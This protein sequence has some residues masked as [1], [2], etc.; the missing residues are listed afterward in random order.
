MNTAA[1]HMHAGTGVQ[2]NP[3]YS[4]GGAVLGTVLVCALLLWAFTHPLPNAPAQ[5][6][7][8]SLGAAP[9]PTPRRVPRPIS[10]TQTAKT[11]T[12]PVTAKPVV[13]PKASSIKPVPSLT[14]LDLNLPGLT[15]APPTA[16]AFQPQVFNPYSDLD[17]ALT[18]PPPALQM[19]N[20]QSYRS[21][22][23]DNVVK[24]GGVCS[25]IHNI[26]VG[27]SPSNHAT[28]AFP[29]S[30]RGAYKPSMADELKAWADTEARKHHAPQ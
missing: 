30:C 12:Q 10:Y 28:V 14:P 8:L 21:L 3:V 16:S 23:G 1:V 25:E 7:Q 13:I 24:M 27:L 17:K 5:L 15:F 6:M 19:K 22:Y 9:G 26:Q 29:G 4:L 11:A 20:G 18:A 2:P